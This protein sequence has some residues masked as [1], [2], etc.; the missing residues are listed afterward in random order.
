MKSII[1]TCLGLLVQTSVALKAI[2]WVNHQDVHEDKLT[3]EHW[4]EEVKKHCEQHKE[5]LCKDV[6]TVGGPN[7]NKINI[8]IG[9]WQEHGD[10][11][12][13]VT[14]GHEFK[15]YFSELEWV[16]IAQWPNTGEMKR[17][18]H[19]DHDSHNQARMDKIKDRRNKQ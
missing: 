1:A 3:I 11:Q 8:D 7:Q 17:G 15:E 12:T 6:T 14:Q 13:F 2:V 5:W 18:K 9:S 16:N 4:V 19:T 10:S